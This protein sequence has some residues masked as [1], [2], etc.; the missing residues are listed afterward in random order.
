MKF[1]KDFPPNYEEICKHFNVRGNKK[2]IFTFGDSI[3]HPYS[4]KKAITT[5]L[6]IHEKT[7]EKQQG[8]DPIGWWKRYFDDPDFRLSQELEAYR[9]QYKFYIK[10]H[11]NFF[12][13]NRFL[14]HIASVLSG[15]NYGGVVNFE[16]AKELITNEN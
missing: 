11:Y 13:R 10:S 15:E 3:Y 14:N 1:V 9:N 6:V 5:D 8:N 12:D 7:H 2:V 4:S 16:K